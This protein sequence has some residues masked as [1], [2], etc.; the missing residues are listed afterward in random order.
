MLYSVHLWS[1]SGQMDMRKKHKERSQV[2]IFS[3][4]KATSHFK[5]EECASHVGGCLI[6]QKISLDWRE[7]PTSALIWIV[8]HFEFEG[9]CACESQWMLH[10][11]QFICNNKYLLW[12]GIAGLWN[13]TGVKTKRLSPINISTEGSVW[14]WDFFLQFILAVN[15]RLSD[16]YLPFL[17]SPLFCSLL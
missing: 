5:V 11:R 9:G 7:T 4:P 10:I 1:F 14:A 6:R 2:I 3:F 12:R 15:D 13:A 16:S 17:L 8:P